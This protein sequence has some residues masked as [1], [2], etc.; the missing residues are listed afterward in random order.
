V[1]EGRT[2]TKPET[3]KDKINF[4]SENSIDSQQKKYYENAAYILKF[5]IVQSFFVVL[6]SYWGSKK[7]EHRK[8][9]Y[10]P[11]IRNHSIY[12]FLCVIIDVFV[13]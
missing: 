1:R 2:F 11:K 5:A 7:F 9:Y 12:F 10:L 13:V 8:A 4:E 3:I 6:L